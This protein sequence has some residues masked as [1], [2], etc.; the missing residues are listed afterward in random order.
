MIKKYNIGDVIMKAVM[1]ITNDYGEY[2]SKP[3]N[4]GVSL[5]GATTA[6]KSENML[7]TSFLGFGVAIT[8]SSC[9]NLSLMKTDERRSL[10]KHI[11]TKEGLNL[12]V[13]RLTI[14]S[15]DYSAEVY[16]Y[17][18]VNDDTSLQH[19]SIERDK[20]YI[21]P[22]IK[23]ILEIKPNLTLFASPWS[24]PAWMK[25]GGSIGGG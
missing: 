5:S 1:Y 15:S 10:L 18:D 20:E 3:L 21:I 8:G 11:Y 12:N 19:F 22:I 13:G 4:Y 24:P 2:I 9:Y 14:G 23:E 17:D 25:T 6:V 16:T 7:N